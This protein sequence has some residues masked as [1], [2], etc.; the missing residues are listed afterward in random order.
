LLPFFSHDTLTVEE[1]YMESCKLANEIRT[2]KE[3]YDL[4]KFANLGFLN[5]FMENE[6]KIPYVMEI[7]KMIMPQILIDEVERYADEK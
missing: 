4:L 6:E 7:I 1:L 3:S 2:D 5:V